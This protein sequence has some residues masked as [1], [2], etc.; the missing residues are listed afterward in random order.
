MANIHVNINSG[1][2]SIITELRYCVGGIGEKKREENMEV[3][4]REKYEDWSKRTKSK[5]PKWFGERP[6][7][8]TGEPDSPDCDD[9]VGE[10]EEEY[11]EEEE[12]EEY[13]EVEE[14]YEE[15]SEEEE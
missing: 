10:H 12:E 7:K 4:W 5:L 9:D 15:Y 2:L 11:S 6:G 13:E 14:E 1:N 8:K 3:S